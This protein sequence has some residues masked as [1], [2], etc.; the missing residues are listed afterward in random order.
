MSTIELVLV[1]RHLFFTL[2]LSSFV[3]LSS[4]LIKLSISTARRP[5]HSEPRLFGRCDGILSHR[6]L[7]GVGMGK[8]P[9]CLEVRVCS[10][11]SIAAE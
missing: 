5:V 4:A 1:T 3:I 6:L 7:R 11:S 8:M 10:E 9:G 2:R